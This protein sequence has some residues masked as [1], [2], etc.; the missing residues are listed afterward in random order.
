M[1]LSGSLHGQC[2][3]LM[4]KPRL[5]GG[6]HIQTKRTAKTAVITPMITSRMAQSFQ[7]R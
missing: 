6:N 4:H 7:T 3:S 5:G 2:I 1:H